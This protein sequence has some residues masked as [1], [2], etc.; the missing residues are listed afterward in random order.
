MLNKM[1]RP[2][3]AL[4]TWCF[5][6]GKAPMNDRLGTEDGQPAFDDPLALTD[7]LPW[8]KATDRLV[9]HGD[10]DWHN[11][12]MLMHGYGDRWVVYAEGYREAADVVVERIKAGHG[13]QDFLVYPVM[14]LYRQFLELSIKGLIRSAWTLF[15]IETSDDLG[16]HD[17]RRYWRVCRELLE[18]A[19]PGDSVAE[20]SHISRLIGEFCDHDP[21]SF[22][23]RYPE[24]KPDRNTGERL[25]TLQKLESI[26]LRNVQ[27]VIA[28]VA[29]LLGAADAHIGHQLELKADMLASFGPGPGDY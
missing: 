14:F 25:P 4:R 12:A 18:R 5:R 29:G 24:S 3:V 8:P 9:T 20:L 19:S 2:M 26:N 27:E 11:R 22:S 1:L 28:N 21:Q 17:L 10:P 16:S 13:H 6:R 23:F 7:K 15:D